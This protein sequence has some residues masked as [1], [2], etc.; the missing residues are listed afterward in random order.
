MLGLK[1]FRF[2]G[3]HKHFDWLETFNSLFYHCP[4]G[5]L[6]STVSLASTCVLFFWFL[7][8]YSSLVGNILFLKVHIRKVHLL[9][10]SLSFLSWFWNNLLS[11]PSCSTYD[12]CLFIYFFKVFTVLISL[13][14]LGCR[15][16]DL[17]RDWTQALCLGSAESW[18]LSQKRSRCICFLLRG[19]HWFCFG[20]LLPSQHSRT[21]R[22]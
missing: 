17:T 8:K 2:L 21:F 4:K 3:Y 18:P 9:C 1:K 15:I 20:R 22:T 7:L 12:S 11:V 10:I 6:P 14:I 16:W 13:A 19:T 5:C